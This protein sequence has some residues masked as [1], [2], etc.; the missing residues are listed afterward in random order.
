M[1]NK[2]LGVGIDV[3][4]RKH[5]I[6]VMNPEKKL[7]CRSFVIQENHAGYQRLL[8]RL[9]ELKTGNNAE[10]ICIGMEATADYWKNLYHF[11][12]ERPEAFRVVV[13]NPVQTRAFAKT[14]LRR[15]KTDP[16]DARIIAQFMVEKNPRPQ[17]VRPAI[18]DHIKDLDRYIN[19]LKKKRNMA[20]N[21]L[22]ME[23]AK[24]A[25]EIEQDSRDITAQKTLALLASYPTADE[26]AKASR[27]ELRNVR[28]GKRQWRLP[29]TFVDKIKELTVES[30]AH[31]KGAGAGLIVQSLVK[32]LRQCQDEIES[33]KD[34]IRQL[35]RQL[36]PN[37]SLLATITG[38]GLETAIAI[39]A[40]IGDV[41][42]FPKA[43]Q[44]VAYFG[45]NPTV[46]QSGESRRA[47]RMEKKGASI[48]RQK[49]YM[50]TINL[51][52]RQQEPIYE[53]YKRLVD[54][55]KP[56]MLAI[57]AAMRKLLTIMYAMLKNQQEFQPKNQENKEQ[58]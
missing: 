30:I 29:E 24:V 16:T 56:K 39:E 50:A 31:K 5:A 15:A 9:A 43:K 25:P 33:G 4:K 26:I 2:R 52:Q 23:L 36:N 34:Q 6:A 57:G 46:S 58:T 32:S 14:E 7:V 3:S 12:R 19:A 35:Y 8:E 42:R 49:L 18:F 21:Q 55:G 13:I 48:I 20:V 38:V 47:S 40:H 44:I 1:I 54:A 10:A 17:P 28:Y 11:L 27:D 51:I 37:D 45:L 22:R 53:Y 41:N